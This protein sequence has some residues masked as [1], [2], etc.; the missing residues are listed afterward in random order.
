[1]SF[2]GGDYEEPE[3]KALVYTVEALHA[4]PSDVIEDLHQPEVR[5]VLVIDLTSD[6]A[7]GGGDMPVAVVAD[8]DEFARRLLEEDVVV[9]LDELF[10]LET[11]GE[12]T[13]R[14]QYEVD[15]HAGR[16]IAMGGGGAG[17]TVLA[18]APS[19]RLPGPIMPPAVFLRYRCRHTLH[20]VVYRLARST[21]KTCGELLPDGA[22]CPGRLDRF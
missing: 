19:P 7:S 22:P 20:H 14:E 10:G 18:M 13:R 15:L 17:R 6:H 12:G 8:A 16:V 2:G 11:G 21:G 1:M 4:A 9:V 5:M 3:G